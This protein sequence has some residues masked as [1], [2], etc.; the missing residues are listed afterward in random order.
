MLLIKSTGECIFS[1]ATKPAKRIKWKTLF[2][3]DNRFPIIRR[4]TASSSSS[5]N[6]FL[7]AFNPIADISVEVSFRDTFA[8]PPTRY[9]DSEYI[10]LCV[11]FA[12]INWIFFFFSSLFNHLFF[13]AL[14]NFERENFKRHLNHRLQSHTSIH[15][16]LMHS[17]W[18][19]LA[20]VLLLSRFRTLNP[21]V[22]YFFNSNTAEFE[23]RETTSAP[24]KTSTLWDIWGSPRL[25]H[26]AK[27]ILMHEQFQ[28]EFK[29]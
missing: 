27:W 20:I 21:T 13:L 14:S 23:T 24:S 4:I 1:Y 28:N 18:L 17:H 6:L 2:R 9:V 25:R 26:Y 8:L 11:E 19:D 7:A 5:Q 29:R 22:F 16:C 10:L 12:I 3:V 15:W